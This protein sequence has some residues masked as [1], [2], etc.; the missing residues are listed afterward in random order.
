MGALA[1]ALVKAGVVEA[2]RLNKI[3]FLKE[4]QAERYSSLSKEIQDILRE[5]RLLKELLQAIDGGGRMHI[6]DIKKHAWDFF[7]MSKE[8]NYTAQANRRMLVDQTK[9]KI[10]S[11]E[12]DLSPRIKES[13]KIEAEW[14]L[15]RN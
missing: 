4:V 3:K 11:L 5:K 13:Q 1:Q 2:E 10:S 15:K 9:K 12:N 14:G 8:I 7:R 6:N